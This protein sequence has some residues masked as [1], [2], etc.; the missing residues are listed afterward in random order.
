VAPFVA[1]R[2]PSTLTRR[3]TPFHRGTPAE[4]GHRC[5]SRDARRATKIDASSVPAS[6][7]GLHA[8]GGGAAARDVRSPDFRDR[9]TAEQEVAFAALLCDQPR[10]T[11][12]AAR[13]RGVSAWRH[14]ERLG[15]GEGRAVAT[16]SDHP[17]AAS[18]FSISSIRG[19]FSPAL[20]RSAKSSRMTSSQDLTP[21]TF[22]APRYWR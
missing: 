3:L 18:L 5:P 4:R 16:A 13:Q 15:V 8:A 11:L 22:F 10:D 7:T 6:S 17:P 14:G 2:R 12:T 19:S 9:S 20:R 21:D 1:R